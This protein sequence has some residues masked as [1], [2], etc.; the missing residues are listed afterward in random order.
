M[1][2]L[3]LKYISENY[4]ELEEISRTMRLSVDKLHQL[5]DAKLIPEPSYTI[6]SEITISSSLN[7]G[8][9]TTIIR[10]YF[11][12]NI[13]KLIEQNAEKANADEFKTEFK[14]NLLSHLKNHDHKMF[15]YGNVFDVNQKI[16][17]N[18]A[19]EAL[20]EEWDY[21]CKGVYGICTIDN[22]ENAI[23]E[24]E[25]AVKRILDFIE[26]KSPLLTPEEKIKLEELNAEFNNTAS[27]F[28]PYQRESSS[29]GKYLDKLLKE[30][31]LDEL[32]KKYD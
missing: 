3:N 16:D 26:N 31:S 7:D 28:A 21:Y 9:K 27:S 32:I 8:Y 13:L 24:K 17:S 10:K 1:K 29:R 19:E 18:K 5:I 12:K 25:I 2:D 4:I 14:E 20:E 23:I 6:N 22:N 15:A 11:P 30:F